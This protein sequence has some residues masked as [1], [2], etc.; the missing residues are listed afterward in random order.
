MLR[1]DGYPTGLNDA[2]AYDGRIFEILDQLESVSDDCYR[3]M[4]GNRVRW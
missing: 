4:I 1:R 2:F 3:L